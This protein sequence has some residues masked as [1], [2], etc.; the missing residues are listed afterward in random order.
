M[1]QTPKS[2][3]AYVG[4]TTPVTLYTV[5]IGATAVV[6]SVV[7]SG[8]TS[9]FPQVTVNKVSGGVIYPLIVNAN[10]GYNAGTYFPENR[11]VN[12]LS[13]PV[14]MT[15]GDVLSISTSSTAYYKFPA[16]T[17]PTTNPY[18]RINNM[19]YLNGK[20]IAVGYDNNVGKGLILTST[21]GITWT[22][23]NFNYN[24]NITDIA[25]DG[26]TNYV[27]VGTNSSGYIYYS[28]D[29]ST[30]TQ[31]ALPSN[32][33]MYCVTYGNGKWLTGGVSG[34]Y[35]YATTPSSWT[36][37]QLASGS[38]INAVLTI[39]TNWAFGTESTYTY[40]SDFSTFVIPYTLGSLSYG[41]F[42]LDTAGKMYLSNNNAVSSNPTNSCFYSTN[43]GKT[44]TAYNFSA[45]SNLPTSGTLPFTFAN[46]GRIFWLGYHPGNSKYVKSSD[47]VTFSS[48]DYSGYT[49]GS[50]TATW[51]STNLYG[52]TNSTYNG[53]VGLLD[54]QNFVSLN[55]NSS[56]TVGYNT[57]WGLSGT[58]I[59]PF[60]YGYLVPIGNT[61]NGSW[62]AISY[63]NSNTTYTAQWYSNSPS[64]GSD[65]T[66]SQNNMNISSYGA[67]ISGCGRPGQAGF[68]IGTD[69]GYVLY[70]SST[71]SGYTTAGRIFSTS[72]AICGLVANGNT[73]ASRIVAINGAGKT[74]YSTDGGATW[75]LGNAINDSFSYTSY[76]NNGGLKYGGGV[77]VAFSTNGVMYYST[78]GIA[79]TGNPVGIKNMYTLNSNNVF[80]QSTGNVYTTG[81]NI[82]TFIAGS[83]S[84]S[85]GNYPSVRR[86]AY[87]G[88]T[89][90]VGA[91]NS[92]FASTDL[93][94]WSSNSFDG[95]QINNQLYYQS[96][97]SSA[98]SIAYS[99]SG[100]SFAIGNAL[101]SQTTDNVSFGQPTALAN[102][103]VVGATTASV[104]E[105][106]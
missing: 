82:D 71:T 63:N 21:D 16:N 66:V 10:A 33:N 100:T 65:G 31:V 22:N 74:A 26:S 57:G 62:I 99:G 7:T 68:I 98:V 85:F 59:A 105:I 70:S 49:Y 42:E 61:F 25:Y 35:F 3:S 9:G 75:T 2:V 38:A 46:G 32:Y 13:G 104:V 88:G 76:I 73:T 18:Q 11:A 29:L 81:T 64:G 1:A 93:V 89:Y 6:K 8:L 52:T 44:S 102:S 20:Y 101:R 50:T 84:A 56:G 37:G 72:N 47:G 14:T 12:L 67:P 83:I 43:Y 97:G 36:A 40:T 39:G 103:L 90:L 51:Y 94:S 41:G 19:N 28:T 55:V 91:G 17:S 106:T 23:Q 30:W 45:L 48:D 60:G 4:S 86:A 15:A 34:R 5:P 27:V 80:I 79:W 77:W 69:S 78:D 54:S 95:T 96:Q 87:V 53:F 92:I 58:Y 24:I